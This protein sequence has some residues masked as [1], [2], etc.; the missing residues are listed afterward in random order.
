METQITDGKISLKGN[1]A[2]REIMEYMLDTYQNFGINEVEN[3]G[4]LQ[5]NPYATKGS[6]AN[7]MK[8]F[9][10]KD[11]YEQAVRALEHEIYSVA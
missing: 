4:I 7:I 8:H 10:G 5:L 3:R 11:K 1:F 6:P 2:V 9:G